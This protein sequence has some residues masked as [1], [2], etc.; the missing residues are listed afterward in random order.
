MSNYVRKIHQLPFILEYSIRT[1]NK[2]CLIWI[3]E[4]SDKNQQMSAK[5][6]IAN[7]YSPLSKK[8]M[9][10]MWRKYQ[11]DLESNYVYSWPPS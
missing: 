7:E 2:C 6:L 4:L 8:T 3:K 5:M 10:V 9:L 11:L 1:S